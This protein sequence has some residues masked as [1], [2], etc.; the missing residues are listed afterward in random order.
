V[1]AAPPPNDGQPD[2]GPTEEN[3]TDAD[4]Y[5][6]AQELAVLTGHREL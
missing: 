5:L 2:H 3:R 6:R 1:Y 4:G